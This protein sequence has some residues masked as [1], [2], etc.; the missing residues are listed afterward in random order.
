MEFQQVNKLWSLL[1]NLSDPCDVLIWL[2]GK[3]A[4]CLFGT[5]NVVFLSVLQD[6]YMGVTWQ[7]K[8]SFSTSNKTA[9]SV[10][11]KR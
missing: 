9:D 2:R 8:P 11:L 5:E 10:E 1:G 7:K 4:S 3:A 6:P